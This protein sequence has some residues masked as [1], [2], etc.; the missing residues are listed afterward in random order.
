MSFSLRPLALSLPFALFLSMTTGCIA[1]GRG[2]DG[3]VH[4]GGS[5]STGRGDPAPSRAP[6]R[7]YHPHD[8]DRQQAR[9]EMPTYR[10]PSRELQ[11]WRCG[12]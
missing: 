12:H 7:A 3:P 9:R 11:C 6:E 10:E 5:G 2:G 8:F 4:S 1:G